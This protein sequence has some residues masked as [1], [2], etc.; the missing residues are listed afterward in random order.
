MREDWQSEGFN[1]RAKDG[2]SVTVGEMQ[3][4]RDAQADRLELDAQS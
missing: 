4:F 1:H 3:D 2:P